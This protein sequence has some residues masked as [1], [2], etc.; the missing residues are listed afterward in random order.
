LGSWAYFRQRSDGLN[1][2][3][4]AG[5]ACAHSLDWVYRVNRIETPPGRQDIARNEKRSNRGY[6]RRPTTSWS[7]N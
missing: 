1:L 5:R 2:K 7:A 4:P 3:T 6:R